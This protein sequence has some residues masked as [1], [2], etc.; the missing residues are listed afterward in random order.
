MRIADHKVAGRVSLAIAAACA[1]ATSCVLDVSGPWRTA[2][3]LIALFGGFFIPLLLSIWLPGVF[4]RLGQ[5]LS[6]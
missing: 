4:K 1:I 5:V 6:N 2:G 3:I